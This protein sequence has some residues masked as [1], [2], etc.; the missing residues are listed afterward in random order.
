[1]AESTGWEKRRRT[2]GGGKGGREGGREG[3]AEG[4]VP[5]VGCRRG[6][7]PQHGVPLAPGIASMPRPEGGEGGREEGGRETSDK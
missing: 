2:K 1:M 5:W 3:E 7:R 4:N 6:C